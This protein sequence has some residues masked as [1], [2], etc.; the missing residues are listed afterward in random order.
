MRGMTAPIFLFTAGTVF[1]YLF[2]LVDRPF[3]QNP[4]V[5]KGIKRSFILIL[6][7]YLLRYP[8]FTLVDFSQVTE[9]QWNGFM[10]VDVLQLIGV[11]LLL[12]LLLLY[13][14][15]KFFHS[16]Y[17][18][19]SF[20]AMAI[21]ILSPL[22]NSVDWS[23]YFP[24]PVAAYLSHNSGSL[25]PI[26]PWAGYL[27]AGSILGSYLAKNQEAFKSALFSVWLATLGAAFMLSSLLGDKISVEMNIPV[28][29]SSAST[30]LVF[31]RV[32]IVLLINAVVSFIALK[33][34]N[35]PKFIILVGRNTLLIYVVHLII[36]YG[37][38]WS[39]GLALLYDKSFTG[40]Q[41]IAAA[42]GMVVLMTL[43]VILIN[44]FKMR[45]K[46]LVA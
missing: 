30:G 8:T 27:L 16:D 17:L 44:L 24:E 26:F 7:G 14:S 23:N 12:T 20:L 28:V 13:L 35:I 37:S 42:A 10:T 46:P 43:L 39:P 18:L 41:S 40:V 6:I 36:L 32:G 15:E 33:I 45:N 9:D 22:V 19:F 3:N 34:E 4:R 31:F 2:R 38:A 11:S 21:F 5:E 25:F 29:D 1:T